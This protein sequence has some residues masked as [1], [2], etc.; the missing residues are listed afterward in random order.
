MRSRVGVV[1]ESSS[2]PTTTS[3]SSPTT[4]SPRT[5]DGCGSTGG[6]LS[7]HRRARTPEVPPMVLSFLTG[8]PRRRDKPPRHALPS[9]DSLAL[10]GKVATEGESRRDDRG[11]AR[12]G[13]RSLSRLR[14]LEAFDRSPAAGEI[15]RRAVPD[16]CHGDRVRD[17]LGQL[18]PR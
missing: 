4:T 7:P 11:L 10:R 2:S 8:G 15:N 14:A 13:P 6:F 16:P 18:L 12:S 9:R 3:S 5:D 17:R 1:G